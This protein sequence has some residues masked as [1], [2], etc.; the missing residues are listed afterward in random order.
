MENFMFDHRAR[1]DMDLEQYTIK[2]LY[3]F[4]VSLEAFNQS[5]CSRG[6]RRIHNDFVPHLTI[7]G[8]AMTSRSDVG[9]H[10]PGPPPLGRHPRSATPLGPWGRHPPPGRCVYVLGRCVYVLGPPRGGGFFSPEINNA[11]V[12]FMGVLVATHAFFS[13]KLIMLS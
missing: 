6:A 10:P 13:R 3:I 4:E 8:H 1:F 9:R 5:S 7:F 11:D 12:A 2:M